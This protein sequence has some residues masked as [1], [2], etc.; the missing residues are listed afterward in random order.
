MV[1][2]RNDYDITGARRAVGEGQ[3]AVLLRSLGSRDHGNR[4]IERKPKYEIPE[5]GYTTDHKHGR[6]EASDEA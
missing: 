5:P 4:V 2:T 1:G 3:P 6:D